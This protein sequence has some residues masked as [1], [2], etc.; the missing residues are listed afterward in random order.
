MKVGLL[1]GTGKLPAAVAAGAIEQGYDVYIAQ[2][3]GTKTIDGDGD[4]YGLGEFGRITKDFKAAR[5]THVC[6]AG[7][8]NR[9]DFK[10]LKPDFKALTK[11]PG[12][13]MA[14][15]EGDD[16]LLRFV[17]QNFEKEGF[18]ILSPQQLCAS[19]LAPSG[20]LGRHK[21]EKSD[22]D[23]AE[24]AMKIARDIGALDIGQGVV[25]CRG[26]T[27]AVEAQEG[28]D[29]MLRRVA[30]LHADIRGTAE[31]PSG[32]LAKMVKPGQDDRID[33]P[34][35]G[36]ETIRLAAQAGLAGIIVEAQRAFVIDR[37]ELIKQADAANIFV[38]GLPSV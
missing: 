1:A 29:A 7:I 12:A 13:L 36:P 22:R 38:V 19:I 34:T 11:L 35:I 37:D 9:P 5:V 30:G 31:R 2:V 21:M 24:K 18:T 4:E 15:R 23:D 16:A 6:F 17:I 27:L 8:V 20:H 26:L 28:T 33:L 14:A 3:Q 32:V 25:V 10:S